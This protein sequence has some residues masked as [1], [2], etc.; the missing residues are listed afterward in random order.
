M[1]VLTMEADA[2]GMYKVSYEVEEIRGSCPLYKVGD[3]A[4][5]RSSGFTEVVDLE[6]SD[7]V[8]HAAH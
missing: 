5:F 8:C 7:A 2:Q 6:E 4:V 1:G 3:K